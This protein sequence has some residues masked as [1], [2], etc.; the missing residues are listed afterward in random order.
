MPADKRES[1]LISVIIPVYNA[2][3]FLPE[4]LQSVQSQTLRDFE[5]IMI[6]DGSTDRSGEICRKFA[7]SDNRFTMIPMSENR[8]PSAARNVGLTRVGGE[9]VLFLDADDLLTERALEMLYQAF[10]EG[11]ADVVSGRFQK[12]STETLYDPEPDSQSCGCWKLTSVAADYLAAPNRN[13][14]FAF[15][16]GRLFRR[17][18]ISKYVIRFDERMFLCE[19]VAL[20]FDFMA[21]SSVIQ[22]IDFCVYRYRIPSAGHM[23]MTAGGESD[24]IAALPMLLEHIDNGI[25]MVNSPELQRL[26]DDCIVNL[27]II[28]IVRMCVSLSIGN[29][30]SYRKTIIHLISHSKFQRCLSH[31]DASQPGRSKLMPL[32]MRNRLGIGVLLLGKYKAIKRYGKEKSS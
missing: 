30:R 27:V 11:N 14:I 9:T 2:E 6:D 15:A 4:C 21:H 12:F 24:R 18:I 1:P 31:Y 26:A 17:D 5:V 32:L 25:R 3:K 10:D 13:R 7:A 16:W 29:F 23:S 19:D 20:N 28:H 22:I 8:G